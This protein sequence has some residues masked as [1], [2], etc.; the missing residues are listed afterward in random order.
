MPS[1]PDLLQC[2]NQRGVELVI[3]KIFENLNL[4]DL[5]CCQL[6]N[7][8]WYY[9]VERLWE[10]H[11]FNRVGKGWLVGTPTSRTLQCEKK[12]AVCT[13]SGIAVDESS[14]LVGLGSSGIIQLWSRRTG[15]KHRSVVYLSHTTFYTFGTKIYTT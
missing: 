10:H 4:E 9:L 7:K 5:Q 12:R 11:E 3:H 13:V 6:V 14:I 8:E 2:L 15:K 1:A